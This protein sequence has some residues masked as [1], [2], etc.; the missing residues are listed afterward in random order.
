MAT[1][2]DLLSIVGEHMSG[3]EK[4]EHAARRG[5][6]EELPGFVSLMGTPALTLTPLRP[7]RSSRWFLYDYPL[8]ADGVQRYDRCLMSEFVVRLPTMNSSHALKLLHAGREKELE[9]EASTIEFVPLNHVIR[10]LRRDPQSFCAPPLFPSALLD[11]YR[12]LCA[13]LRQEG[14]S[15]VP[16]PTVCST[17]A[18]SVSPAMPEVLDESLVV[19]GANR[20]DTTASAAAAAASDP[21]DPTGSSLSRGGGGRL[22]RRLGGG[23]GGGGKGGGKG[24]GGGKGAGAR[25]AAGSGIG[26]ARIVGGIAHAGAWS[27]RAR[28]IASPSKTTTPNGGTIGQSPL[29]ASSRACVR[30]LMRSRRS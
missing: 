21:A 19:K 30:R 1:C 29:L 22:R 12:D 15:K 2:P 11:S 20:T 8:S 3:R 14:A 28:L 4:E 9:H 7:G 6:R 16:I 27:T 13:V 5:I 25:A 24:G 17:A 23:K 18:S 26:T 10:R